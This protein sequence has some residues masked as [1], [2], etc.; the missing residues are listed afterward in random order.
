MDAIIEKLDELATLKIQR[1]ALVE[2]FQAQIMAIEVERDFEA[3]ELDDRILALENEVKTATVTYG[4][5]VKGTFMRAIFNRGRVSWN[6]KGLVG[7]SVANPEILA[8][9]KQGRPYVSLREV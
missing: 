6:T 3:G 1:K 5:S 4:E 2:P 9:R 8:F 7:Y